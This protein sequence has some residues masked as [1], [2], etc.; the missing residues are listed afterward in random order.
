METETVQV[1]NEERLFSL[2]SHLSIFLGG[3]VLPIIFWVINKDKSKFVT[4]HSL[5]AIFYYIAYIFII[6]LLVV[7]MIGGGFGLALLTAGAHA[8]E[9]NAMPAAFIIAMLIFYFLLFVVIFGFIG[10][11]IYVGIKS[12]GG[13][14]K[15]YPVI[16]NIVYKSVYGEK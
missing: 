14:L 12:Y 16:G 11:G 13:E 5:Q 7:I 8:F 2:F 9:K 15:R 1:T 6:I 3:I 10:Y 4:F